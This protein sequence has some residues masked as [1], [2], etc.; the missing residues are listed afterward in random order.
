MQ[1]LKPKELSGVWDGKK[2]TCL[3]WSWKPQLPLSSTVVHSAGKPQRNEFF[4][5][6]EILSLGHAVTVLAGYVNLILK[7]LD[8]YNA[9]SH[10][11]VKLAN[12]ATIRKKIYF[13]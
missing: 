5:P 9:K 13:F 2:K 11:F 12:L 7:I 6:K 4:Q 8:F 10:P 3:V 1:Y